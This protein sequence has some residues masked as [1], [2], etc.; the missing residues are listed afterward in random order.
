VFN[1]DGFECRF[2]I[3]AR[4]AISIESFSTYPSQFEA[5][6]LPGTVFYILERDGPYVVMEE[7]M[8]K[9]LNARRAELP[10]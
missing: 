9:K 1:I 5:V 2:E 3:K 4:T 7:I 8:L 6:F 10:C